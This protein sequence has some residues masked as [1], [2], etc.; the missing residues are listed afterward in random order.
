[1]LIF[2]VVIDLFSVD[3]TVFQSAQNYFGNCCPTQCGVFIFYFYRIDPEGPRLFSVS[4]D[5]LRVLLLIWTFSVREED[6]II[7]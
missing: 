4:P 2:V 1:M 3:V 5:K 7:P 6:L